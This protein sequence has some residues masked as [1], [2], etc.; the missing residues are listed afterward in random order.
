MCVPSFRLCMSVRYKQRCDVVGTRTIAWCARGL[1]RRSLKH[2]S[3]GTGISFSEKMIILI[4]LN[5]NR[6]ELSTSRSRMKW[7]KRNNRMRR[8][9][10]ETNR[11]THRKKIKSI[12]IFCYAFSLLLIENANIA[13]KKGREKGINDNFDGKKNA[14]VKNAKLL[15]GALQQHH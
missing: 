15:V 5:T 14:I 9:K 1:R 2:H 13:K 4:I 11:K 7:Q 12:R 6:C 8:R 10:I 3:L